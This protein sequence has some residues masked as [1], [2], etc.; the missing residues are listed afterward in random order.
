MTQKPLNATDL[1]LDICICGNYTGDRDKL[2]VLGLY[3]YPPINIAMSWKDI[4]IPIMVNESSWLPGPYD[5]KGL[6][7]SM[8][9]DRVIDNYT[10]DSTKNSYLH[11]K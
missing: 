8:E 9:K 1:F 7:Q 11:G 6:S 10:V 3:P 5:N 2:Y 4:Y